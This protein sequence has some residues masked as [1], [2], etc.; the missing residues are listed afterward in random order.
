MTNS[1]LIFYQYLFY[2]NIFVL[3]AS[4]NGPY[5]LLT[6]LILLF[7]KTSAHSFVIPEECQIVTLT[8]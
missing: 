3:Y 8:Y 7:S 1:I 6:Y 4:F 5:S 2:L